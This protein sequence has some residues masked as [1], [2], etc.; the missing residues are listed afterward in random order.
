MNYQGKFRKVKTS[1]L[2]LLHNFICQMRI[3]VGLLNRENVEH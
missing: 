1:G 2:T 3:Y